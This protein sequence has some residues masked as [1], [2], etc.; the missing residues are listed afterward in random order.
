[1]AKKLTIMKLTK[2]FGNNNTGEVCGFTA[3]TA[4]HIKKNDGGVIL[5]E[6]DPKTQRFDLDANK[7]VALAK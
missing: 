4:A 3:E 7:V 5:A 6:I 1:M 2:Q